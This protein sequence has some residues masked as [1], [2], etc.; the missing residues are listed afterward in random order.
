MS[1]VSAGRLSPQAEDTTWLGGRS[2]STVVSQVLVFYFMF[3]VYRVRVML[4]PAN[5]LL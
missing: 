5:N 4:R 1:A 2:G 3:P